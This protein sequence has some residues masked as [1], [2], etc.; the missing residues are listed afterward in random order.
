M[1]DQNHNKTISQTSFSACRARA[2]QLILARL[3][4]YQG[5]H[6]SSFMRVSIKDMH[7][8][9]G[10]CSSKGNLNFNYRILF[11][12]VEL[13]DYIIVHELVHLQEMNHSQKFWRQVGRVIPDY[14]HRLLALRRMERQLF[15]SLRGRRIPKESEL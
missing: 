9:W 3:R 2:R 1:E 14:K 7:T 10:S 4:I 8:R 12:P 13:V 6:G 11:L 5:I 15:T